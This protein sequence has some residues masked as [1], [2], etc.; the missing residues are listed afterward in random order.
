LGRQRGQTSVR[1]ARK[2]QAGAGDHFKEEKM[3]VADANKI[4][5]LPQAA[6]TAN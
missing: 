4:P 1:N 6:E 3:E 5:A 2:K